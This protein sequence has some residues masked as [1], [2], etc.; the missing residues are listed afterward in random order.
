MSSLL[1]VLAWLCIGLGAALTALPLTTKR[2]DG[3]GMRA[4][5]WPEFCVGLSGV[6]VGL[7]LLGMRTHG[8]VPWLFS[9]PLFT[10]VILNL[11]LWIRSR[12][13]HRSGEPPAGA[14]LGP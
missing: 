7:S 13:H 6:S 3:R 4:A 8:T 5:A 12:I 9:I 11:A 1:E 10:M 2:N 14:S